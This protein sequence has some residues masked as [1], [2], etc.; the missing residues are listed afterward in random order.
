MFTWLRN[1]FGTFLNWFVSTTA[2]E[3]FARHFMAHLTFRIF[4]Y[5]KFPL[6]K[7][8]EV[9]AAFDK[10]PKAI[11]A[12][13]LTDPACLSF[14]LDRMLTKCDWAHAGIV[15]ERNGHLYGWHMKSDG[16]NHWHLLDLLRESDH[17]ALLRIPIEGT[18]VQVANDRLNTIINT[19]MVPYNFQFSMPTPVIEWLTEGKPLSLIGDKALQ[20]LKLYCSEFVFVIGVGLVKNPKFVARWD[21]GQN[22]F[23]PDDLYGSC[24][25]VFEY[26]AK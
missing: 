4:G 26:N 24:S 21:F 2:W 1:L 5:T 13:V 8:F 18:D 17:F 25:V 14:K 12:F 15:V 22:V 6:E 9:K 16:L 20:S 7:Y 10:D 3:M 11:Y 19:P 23:E